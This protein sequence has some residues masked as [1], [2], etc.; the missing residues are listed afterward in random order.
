MDALE[1]IPL[2]GTEGATNQPCWSPDGKSI[3]FFQVRILKKMRVPDGA[4]ETLTVI[5]S[6][7][8]GAS[9]GAGGTLMTALNIAGQGLRLHTI[10]ATG[11]QL[12][13]LEIDALKGGDFYNPEF[14]PN[15]K[16]FLFLWAPEGENEPG[17]YLATL[18]AGKVSR[19]PVLL[20]K[21]A[22]AGRYWQST[23]GWLLFVQNDNLYA[24]EMDAKAR[25]LKGEPE[26]V[27]QGVASAPGF[28][29]ANVSVSQSGTL[30][31]RPGRAAVSQITWFDRQGKEIATAGPPAPFRSI[32]LSPDE[33]RVAAQIGDGARS[34]AWIIEPHQ[35]GYA[36]LPGLLRPLWAS[37]STLVYRDRSRTGLF[38]YNLDAQ[39]IEQI[40]RIPDLNYVYDVR[41]EQKL[42]LYSSLDMSLYADRL[43]TGQTQRLVQAEGGRQIVNASF[44]PNGRWVVYT[45]YYSPAK[46]A[47][48][49][50]R[51]P[52][53]GLP[54]QI[55]SEASGLLSSVWGRDGKEILYHDGSRVWAVSVD[56]LGTNLRLGSAKPLFSVRR[57]SLTNI[58]QALQVT[59]DGSRIICIQSVEQPNEHVIQ[60]ASGWD[61]TLAK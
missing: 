18:D 11:G 38:R 37:D 26:I 20:R 41:S 43:D 53:I 58:D 46:S 57:P 36:T 30:A 56:D 33:K 14:L 24:Q 25:Q 40:G 6:Y 51:F 42:L 32:R 1:A 49:T 15:G 47:I 23:R 4:P 61:S 2:R 55:S 9:W 31:W 27:M 3:A 48:Y 19:G 5:P 52:P 50:Q 7:S 35:S 21:N 28:Y 29:N 54:K 8:R 39:Q 34:A 60:V 44:S 45:A 13:K 22:T 16:D 12:S 17:L 10:P 59:R